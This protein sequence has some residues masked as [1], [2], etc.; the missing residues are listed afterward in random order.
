[1]NIKTWK[2]RWRNPWLYK[3]DAMQA[4][5]DEL[6]AALKGAELFEQSFLYQKGK[7]ERLQ[8]ELANKTEKLKQLSNADAM[9]R[10][11]AVGLE[12]EHEIT[13]QRK[14][15][16]QALEALQPFANDAKGIHPE[17]ANERQRA[18]L[19]QGKPIT[20]GDLRCA[21]VAITAIQGVLK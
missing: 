6:R 4:E 13:A 1:M 20:V 7:I 10:L 19:T 16:E 9:E 21:V 17:W 12:Q 8:A 3:R 14:V 15:L 18:S 2:E 11:Y 5:I